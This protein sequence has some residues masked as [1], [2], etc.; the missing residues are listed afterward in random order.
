MAPIHKM[1]T[2]KVQAMSPSWIQGM[3]TAPVPKIGTRNVYDPCSQD[4]YKECI[5]HL[6]PRWVRECKRPCP[7]D[8]Y[9]E[10]IRPCPQDGYEECIRPCP[11]DG[12]EECIGDV[13]KMGRD[14]TKKVRI[15]CPQ[16]GYQE[17]TVQTMS[18]RWVQGMY[19]APVPKMGTRNVY[20]P[21]S[22][23]G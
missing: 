4:G 9:E 21:S 11:Q 15:M 12:Y 8:G 16:G 10:C 3:Y 5:R 17:G 18:Q 6:F 19:T 1:G 23:D 22:Q 13:S 14:R 20:G 2:R 7:Q